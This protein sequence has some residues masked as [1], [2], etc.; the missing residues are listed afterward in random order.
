MY[1]CED[2]E[3]VPAIRAQPCP[4]SPRPVYNTLPSAYTRGHAVTSFSYP[5]SDVPT[6]P[7]ARS[8]PPRLCAC[9]PIACTRGRW[10][11]ESWGLGR[12]CGG[13]IGPPA[14]PGM[15]GSSRARKQG[16]WGS[17]PRM[18]GAEARR[19]DPPPG[20][21]GRGEVHKPGAD[22]LA[23]AEGTGGG[24]GASCTPGMQGEGGAGGEARRVGWGAGVAHA[25]GT[26]VG[27]PS[28]LLRARV[29]AGWDVWAGLGSPVLK[30]PGCARAGARRGVGRGAL[31]GLASPGLKGVRGA[32][33]EEGAMRGTQWG[34][35]VGRSAFGGQWGLQIWWGGL[36]FGPL[37]VWRGRRHTPAPSSPAP[38]LPP[39]TALLYTDRG[40][41]VVSLPVPITSLSSRPPP[42][43]QTDA[44]EGQYT[45]APLAPSARETL[46]QP[47]CPAPP[48][49]ARTTGGDG[50][51]PSP[52]SPGDAS[53]ANAPRPAPTCACNRRGRRA[54]SGPLSAGDACPPAH[55]PRLAPARAHPGP[56]STGDPSPAHASHPAPTRARNR[57]D[58]VP[59]PVPSAWAT[60][61]PQPTRLAS[62]LPARARGGDGAYPSPFSTGDATRPARPCPRTQQEGGHAH[63]GPL[64]VG[65]A[66]PAPCTPP[67]PPL[68]CRACRKLR[69][70]HQSPP[71]G[72]SHRPQ[73]YAPCHACT[74]L[75]E[76]R[77]YGVLSPPVYAPRS[78]EMRAR[79]KAA[80]EEGYTARGVV[81][82][83]H[84][85]RTEGSHLPRVH[86]MGVQ[87]HNLGGGLRANGRS[88]F[89][90]QERDF[91]GTFLLWD[92]TLC[93]IVATTVSSVLGGDPYAVG[94]EATATGLRQRRRKVLE[95]WG[96]TEMPL[97]W[98]GEV[99][100]LK[101]SGAVAAT[102]LVPAAW[103]WLAYL[104]GTPVGACNGSSKTVKR[105]KK[106]KEK[107]HLV[108]AALLRGGLSLRQTLFPSKSFMFNVQL[109]RTGFPLPHNRRG[110][111][112]HDNGCWLPAS[113]VTTPVLRHR[114]DVT[115]D[116]HHPTWTQTTPLPP[117]QPNP[118]RLSNRQRS[119]GVC[120]T[121]QLWGV[122]DNAAAGRAQQCSCGAC[123]TMQLRGVRNNAAVGRARQRS[124]GC[125]GTDDDGDDDGAAAGGIGGGDVDSGRDSERGDGDGDGDAGSGDADMDG[126]NGD[127]VA[128][129]V[130]R[131]WARTV[132]MQ[133]GTTLLL[134]HILSYE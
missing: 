115:T 38:F 7:F 125:G 82:P 100:G 23:H 68:A 112:P 92:V 32:G 101:D 104:R 128:M 27:T 13:R 105:I 57:R 67:R 6:L 70:H 102:Q 17:V 76:G 109:G 12:V 62:P 9:T 81:Q 29:G 60:P 4:G 108:A 124:H 65:D 55:A 84:G 83:E 90:I 87:A 31:A 46:A 5:H 28:L 2:M 119:C 34:R 69:A 35:E 37:S 116:I 33:G 71:R 113:D 19:T 127:Q 21:R 86:A 130:M 80:R 63:P 73:V 53:P 15:R 61:A 25:E 64:S 45:P 126:D 110:I 50:A 134:V 131:A 66:S 75:E 8:P 120:A 24:R 14:L 11:A 95:G 106:E 96:S 122:R 93:G 114:G 18:E 56:F 42:F 77:K 132:G 40:P 111:T 3:R 72:L 85:W 78:G 118:A 43:A 91:L 133:T 22:G 20:V 117:P 74:L 88:R 107:S 98:V 54:H 58:G 121:T 59:T 39:H 44:Q 36:T 49:P 103:Q 51:Y 16:G 41:K 30:G 1:G 26:G 52:F 129:V 94:V 89:G 99:G 10:D 97:A 79:G 48:L 123:A 47:T